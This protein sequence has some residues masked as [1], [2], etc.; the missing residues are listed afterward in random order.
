MTTH[1]N[2]VGFSFVSF[3]LFFLVLSF[4]MISLGAR[5]VYSRKTFTQVLIIRSYIKNMKRYA[6]IDVQNTESTAQQSCGFSVDWTKLYSWLHDQKW[7][8]NEVFFYSGIESLEDPLNQEFELISKLP[9][10]VVRVKR[11][12]AYKKPNKKIPITC[13]KCGEENVTEVSMGYRKKANCDVELTMDILDT[14]NKDPDVELLVFTGDGDFECLIQRAS[15]VAKKIY[16]VSNTKL[17]KKGG[18]SQGHFSTKLKSL[19][20]EK[21]TNIVF[22]DIDTWKYKIKRDLVS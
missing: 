10:A 4:A 12:F 5:Y 3:P 21:D 14:V 18:L 9:G 13:V 20:E 17:F 1:L 11:V 8:C 6:F 15:E 2:K 7:S 16:I 19:L 22:I